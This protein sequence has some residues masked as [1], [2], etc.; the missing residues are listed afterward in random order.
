MTT[1]FEQLYL[2]A[3]ADI[4]NNNYHE[5]FQK[6]ESI[7]YD[8]PDFAPAHNSIGWIYKTQFDN[9]EKAEMHF[10]AAMRANPLYPHPYFHMA[11]I[12]VDLERFDELQR[13]LDKCL[14]VITIEKSWVHYRFGL[15]NEIKGNYAAAIKNYQQAILFCMNNDKVKD[16]QADIDRTKTKMEI[17]KEMEGAG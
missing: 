3:E 2:E 8:E 13:H 17:A 5:A 7:L 4:R 1:S 10:K 12:Y 16:Y 6:Y 9:Y 15:M 14:N 11:S